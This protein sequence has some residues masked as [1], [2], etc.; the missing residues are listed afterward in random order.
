[1]FS[2]EIQKYVDNH[3]KFIFSI[4]Q[5]DCWWDEVSKSIPGFVYCIYKTQQYKG[6][7]FY[8]FTNQKF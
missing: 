2:I 5:E 8:L 1:M 4:I 6:Q 3:E 7:T